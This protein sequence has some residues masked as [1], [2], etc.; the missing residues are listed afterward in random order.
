MAHSKGIHWD[1]FGWLALGAALMALPTIGILLAHSA[2][3][4]VIWWI[5]FV[6]WSCWFIKNGPVST[7]GVFLSLVL[8]VVYFEVLPGGRLWAYG[9]AAV[10]LIFLTGAYHMQCKAMG[11]RVSEAAT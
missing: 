6:I 11:Y 2:L 3:W 5:V 7:V 1:S 4:N 9:L 8:T 10:Q